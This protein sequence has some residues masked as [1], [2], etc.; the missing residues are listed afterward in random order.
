M[1]NYDTPAGAKSQIQRGT[2][3]IQS[4]GRLSNISGPGFTPIPKNVWGDALLNLGRVAGNLAARMQQARMAREDENRQLELAKLQNTTIM[5]DINDSQAYKA[6]YQGNGDDYTAGYNKAFIEK[7]SAIANSIQDPK[8]R[9]AYQEFVLGYQTKIQL[10]Q[11]RDQNEVYL[12]NFKSSYQTI[13]TQLDDL[14]RTA[15][16]P[17]S[18]A[19][20]VNQYNE[21]L[22]QQM[23]RLRAAGLEDAAK[24]EIMEKRS[25][26]AQQMILSA[27]K[28]D[29]DAAL[30]YLANPEINQYIPDFQ[31]QRNL[32]THLLEIKDKKTAAGRKQAAEVVA[33]LE[34]GL[35]L[36]K[37]TSDL[38]TTLK[39]LND[40]G[41]VDDQIKQRVRVAMELAPNYAHLRDAMVGLSKDQLEE[42]IA[43]LDP[44]NNAAIQADMDL[45]EKEA[46]HSQAA[47]VL[48]R[49]WAAMQMNPIQT[50]ASITGTTDPEQ[51]TLQ[52]VSARLQ[53]GAALS[54]INVLDK[55]VATDIVNRINNAVQAGNIE[56][57][58]SIFNQ[59]RAQYGAD[60]KN[61]QRRVAP[62]TDLMDMVLTQL[63]KTTDHPLSNKIVAAYHLIP[64]GEDAGADNT[65][66]FRAA[67]LKPA[68]RKQLL[69]SVGLKSTQAIDDELRR[70]NQVWSLYFGNQ[71]N[72][73]PETASLLQSQK[74]L[75]VDAILLARAAGGYQ[76]TGGINIMGI[77]LGQTSAT[78]NATKAI[79]DKYLPYAYV[80]GTGSPPQPG[81][82]TK[83]EGPLGIKFQLD[84][85]DNNIKFINSSFLVPKEYQDILTPELIQMAIA[86]D[87][88]DEAFWSARLPLPGAQ[89]TRT[90]TVDP[91]WKQPPEFNQKV[92]QIA[93]F[94][95]ADANDLMAVMKYE[96]GFNPAAKNKNSTASGLIQW[97][98]PPAGVA[99]NEELRKMSAIDQLN[100]VQQWF[101]RFRGKL[102]SPGRVY[103]AVAAPSILASMPADAGPDFVIYRKG[104]AEAKANP[105]WQD[106]SGNVTL[107]RLDFL[108]NQMKKGIGITVGPQSVADLKPGERMLWEQMQSRAKKNLVLRNTADLSG[109]HVYTIINGREVP[110][111]DRITGKPLTYSFDQISKFSYKYRKTTFDPSLL[112]DGDYWR[113]QFGNEKPRPGTKLIK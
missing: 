22:Q 71:A 103:A 24:Q 87:M 99:S 83:I 81:S 32:E 85:K 28:V 77:G 68:E 92:E 102:T 40:L 1:A 98:N 6:N 48:R 52:F 96:S 55:S 15:P 38:Q 46:F 70:T 31:I 100:Y 30:G 14:I 18:L 60:S 25:K 2:P 67:F 4:T 47:N 62:G 23:P 19:Y 58:V 12:N 105:S 20:G 84:A 5:E 26:L 88:R 82:I 54:D 51:A 27:G 78:D 97:M 107:G 43:A 17:E 86:K 95:G 39:N 80:N 75:L 21:L 101:S 59:L 37:D 108:V 72:I 36:G 9:S 16:T 69:E 41:Y 76:A 53:A 42:A 33:D 49:Q 106:A 34:A 7:T 8:L 111:P 65:M 3:E 110:I 13:D 57:V 79:V 56:Q 109:L 74:A 61:P 73:T 104:S 11:L 66:L 94:V 89:T 63:T 64:K 29:V 45:T 10:R 91:R 90:T 44:A 50:M 113:S 93:K 35:I 112:I